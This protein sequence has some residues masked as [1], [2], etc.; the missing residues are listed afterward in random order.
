[1][2]MDKISPVA[3]EYE[4]KDSYIDYAMSVIVSR[5]LPDVRDGL[6]PVHRRILYSM[7]NL[8]LTPDRPYRKSATIV[9]DVIGKYHPH[10]DQSIYDALVRLAQDFNMRYPLVQG[11][12]NFGSLDGDPAAAYRY[13]EARMSRIALELLG[14]I[15]KETVDFRDNFD[16]SLQEPTV[17]PSRIPSLL[18]NGSTGIAVGMATNIPP[19]NLSEVIDALSELIDNPET[20]NEQLIRIVKA[21]DFPT[22]GLIMGI[23][24]CREAYRTGRGSVTMRARIEVEERKNGRQSLIVT[25][26]PYQINKSRLIEQLA[27][28]IRDKKISHVSDLRDESDRSG[29]RIVLELSQN[30]NVQLVL[31]QLYKHS[32]LQCSFGIIMLALVDGE[33]KLLSL[34]EILAH[35]LDHR[36]EV[37]IRRTMFEL[38]KAKN[39]AHI[40]EALRKALD[41]IDEIINIIRSSHDNKQAKES[42]MARFEFSEIQAQAILEMQLQRLTGLQ[43]HKL[44]EEYQ[45][46]MAR[47]AYYEDLL[48]NEHKIMALIKDELLEIKAKYGDKRR[49]EIIFE[50]PG[51]FEI[52]DL[53]PEQD[54]VITISNSGYIKRMSLD[55]YRMQ[56]RGGK[57]VIGAGLKEEDFLDHVCVTTT[58]HYLFFITSLGKMYRLKAYEVAESSRQA[59]GTAII[60]LLPVEPNERVTSM[61]A[62]REL[63]DNYYLVMATREG[64]VK[65]TSLMDYKNVR[66]TGIH[67]IKLGETDGLIGAALMAKNG[68][69]ELLLVSRMGM[70]IRFDAMSVRPTGRKTMGVRT[71]KLQ[72]GDEL[73]AMVDTRKGADLFVVTSRGYSVRVPLSEYRVQGRRGKGIR[74]MKLIEEKGVI[75]AASVVNDNDEILVVTREGQVVRTDSSQIPSGSRNRQGNILIRLSGEDLVSGIAVLSQQESK[76][77]E[78]EISLDESGNIPE[79][80]EI[81]YIGEEEGMDALDSETDEAEDLSVDEDDE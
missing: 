81:E 5:A 51:V 26:I 55:N 33:P 56:N 17:L 15:D 24:G 23:E 71:M 18:V 74:V 25:E 44:E 70:S 34:K 66:K 41:H 80:G 43:R 75:V 11:H 29:I 37:V 53:I 47:I 77:A 54:V 68:N 49:T 36:K 73:V 65:K 4:M 6:K 28:R 40:L 45:E 27:D 22:A 19:H 78:E 38:R 64:F 20:D 67:A 21:P 58:H 60:N 7:D 39:R 48:E 10:G 61:V 63:S 62:I 14:D 13:T 16:A 9:G 35:Y 32:N 2:S 76:S 50:G 3:I 69:R 42:L 8:N 52:E 31:N 59:K 72:D 12:G 79:E 46:L 1:M 30:A 57:G